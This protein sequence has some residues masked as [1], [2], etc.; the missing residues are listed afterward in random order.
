MSLK[1]KHFTA[2][3]TLIFQFGFLQ[4]QQ[5]YTISGTITDAN[6]GETMIATN[7]FVEPL[8]KGATTNLYGFYSL[9]VPEGNYTLKVSFLGYETFSQEIK[10]DKDLEFNIEMKESSYTKEEVVVT[11]EK[12]D[13]NTKSSKMST[14]EIPIQ[15]VKEL[16]ALLGEVDIIKV[17]QLMPGVQSGSEGNAGLY[18]RG[19]G[20]DQNLVLLDEAVVYNA[21]H[22]FGFLSVFNADAI[23]GIE[24]IKGGM[25]AKYGGRLASVLDISMKDGNNKKF[26][27]DG[28]IGII[29]SRL[30]LQGPIVKDK[31]SFIVSGRFAY[32]GLLGGAIANAATKD[33]TN[34]GGF[35]A[36]ASYYFFDLNGK[37]SYNLGS[38]DRLFLS[39][40]FGR[41]V[42]GFKSQDG[43]S[44]NIGWGNGTASLRWNHIFTPKLFMNSSLIFSDYKFE[45]GAGQQEFNL[46]LQSGIRDYNLKLDL[47]WLPDVRHNVQFG[48][49]YIYHT[50]TPSS[51]SARTGD[52][53]LDLGGIIRYHAHEAA[54]YIQDDWDISD[55]FKVNV[56]IRGSLFAHTG[57]FDRYILN[58]VGQV[59]DTV[60]YKVGQNIKTYA[61]AE[62]RVSGRVMLGKHNSIKASYTMN[63]QYIHLASLASISFPTDLWMPST[64]R[65]K[66]QEGH[67]WALGY[68]H[69]FLDNKLEVSVEGYYKTMKNLIEY[70]DGFSPDQNINNNPDNNFVFGK[71]NSY[72]AEFFIRKNGKKF[73]GWIGY[74]LAWTNRKFEALNNGNW[75]PATYDRRHDLSIVGSYRINERWSVSAV[76]VYGT[77]SAITV[78]SSR[79]FINGNIVTEYGD[80]N[81]Y[82]MPDYHR[83]DIGAT[84]HP[85]PKKNKRFK[86]TWNFGI[87]NVYSRQNP[88]FIYFAT[89][90]NE[91]DQTVKIEARQVSIFPIL[92]SVTWN[93]KF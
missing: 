2:L 34:G 19:G 84:L 36:G 76:F 72:G 54:I 6:N 14:V 68:F 58:E 89:K 63:Y 16:P 47:S 90:V 4:A 75:F 69:N 8:M 12:K 62:P 49:N 78:P 39:G 38:K 59:V 56:G 53:E 66:P 37:M 7:V 50:F 30:T 10:L 41:D 3:L 32:A 23:K 45:F 92:P 67:Q 27:V 74:T 80:R 52:T 79:Y 44:A 24:L 83:L 71:G 87:Y 20:P 93:F 57:P 21:S 55:R 60:K 5:K 22:L 43:F 88:Y 11:G 65:V 29:N 70:K 18:V 9:T 64:D 48:G 28:G 35:F 25:P 31:G 81:S 33:N 51:V 85:N 73:N 15:Q 13:E 86:S 77:G 17:I 42:F 46:T 61:F 91:E 26:E 1:I 40:Y 82:R